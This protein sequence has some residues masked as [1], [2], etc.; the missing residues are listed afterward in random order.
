MKQDFFFVYKQACSYLRGKEKKKF[1]LF[2]ILTFMRQISKHHTLLN[3]S[4]KIT[5]SLIDIKFQYF[6][7]PFQFV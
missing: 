2:K 6:L 7:F 1:F 3:L 5:G 4:F